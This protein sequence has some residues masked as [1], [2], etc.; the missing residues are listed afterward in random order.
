MDINTDLSSL[1]MTLQAQIPEI[2]AASTIA[3][4]LARGLPAAV[5][6]GGSGKGAVLEISD[7]ALTLATEREDVTA[8][9]SRF[10]DRS[11]LGGL[12]ER[13]TSPADVVQDRASLL[14]D[15]SALIPE[16][17]FER[18]A[19]DLILEAN[20]KIQDIAIA[21]NT[22]VVSTEDMADVLTAMQAAAF[23]IPPEVNGTLTPQ[24]T[25]TISDQDDPSATPVDPSIVASDGPLARSVM[26][27]DPLAVLQDTILDQPGSMLELEAHRE[28]F[29][30]GADGEN[31]Q[32]SSAPDAAVLAQLA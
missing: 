18:E 19:S 12:E 22:R 27:M 7:E 8:E 14:L 24:P 17:L 2:P 4:S 21:R 23:Q 1:P 29:S 10:G 3:D 16:T 30:Y 25:G 13:R 9:E 15:G 32:T 31:G 26:G 6:L 5:D 28:M 11:I 20:E